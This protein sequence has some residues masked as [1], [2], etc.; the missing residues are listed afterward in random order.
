MLALKFVL[1]IVKGK[2][3]AEFLN[4]QILLHIEIV[5]GCTNV[6]AEKIMHS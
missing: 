4:S 5:F 6:E 1:K 3:R 2:W